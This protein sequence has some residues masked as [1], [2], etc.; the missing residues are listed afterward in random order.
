M[1]AISVPYQFLIVSAFQ[2]VVSAS[3]M[4]RCYRFLVLHHLK[5]TGDLEEAEKYAH[6]CCEFAEVRSIGQ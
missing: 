5:L 3:D 2:S 6:K 1:Q 4:S